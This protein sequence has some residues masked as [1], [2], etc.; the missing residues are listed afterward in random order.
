MNV[1]SHSPAARRVAGGILSGAFV[2]SASIVVAL[3]AFAPTEGVKLAVGQ[4]A[5]NDILAPHSLTYESEVLT[6]IA[7]Q[8]ASDA[9]RPIYDPPDPAVLRQ[10]VQLGRHIL[11][12]IDNVR[13]DSYAIPS[14]QL[15]DLMAIEPL[16]VEQDTYLGFLHITDDAWKDIDDQVMLILERSMRSAVREDNIETIYANLPNLVSVN[17]GD[18]QAHLV[19]AL[20]KNLIKPNTFYNEERTRLARHDAVAAAPTVTRSFVQGQMVAR[21]GSIVT[22]ADME[23]L[24]ELKLLQPDDKRWQ[25]FLSALLAVGTLTTLCMGYIARFYAALLRQVPSMIIIGGLALLWLTGARIFSADSF[26]AHTYPAAAFALAVTVLVEPQVAIVLTAALAALIGLAVGNSI[27]VLLLVAVSGTAGV[28]TLRKTER[29]STYIIAGLVIGVVNGIVSV[30]FLLLQG[31]IDP[32]H[33]LTTLI[34]GMIN[35]TLSAGLGI[36]GLYFISSALNLPTSV[37]LLELSQPSQPLLQRLLRE[38]PGT[39]QHSLQVANLAELAAE[40]L[41]VNPML[42]RVAALYHDVGKLSSPYYFVE[43]QA[44]GVNPHDALADPK[45]SARIIIGHVTEGDKLARKYHLPKMISDFILQHHGTT[46]VLYFYNKALEAVDCD[47]SKVDRKAFE[48]PGPRPQSREAGILM[49]ADSSESIIRAKR[50]RNKQEIETI[51]KEIVEARL[52]DG[53]L[54]TSQLTVNDLRVISE[55]F[56]STLQGVFHPRIAYP[57]LTTQELKAV[58]VPE[59]TTSVT[60]QSTPGEAL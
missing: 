60:S 1:L 38:A 32:I 26:Q 49:L 30:A 42:M 27:E 18:T 51:I 35:G 25:I 37:K 20:S 41:G 29:L 7:Q 21:A 33:V 56:V 36:V 6:R 50:P 58:N 55:V 45:R 11:D 9:I 5:P 10:Q 59:P 39:Y 34:A 17:T 19:V 31:S 48:Y 12:Y 40:R 53:Q 46:I 8:T 23:A 43:N 22:D 47:D 15:A 16:R 52:A 2:V 28:L 44:D 14:Q 4:V 13:H 24:T 54:D 57:S 3:G